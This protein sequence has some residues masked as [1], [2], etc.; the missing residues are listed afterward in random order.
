MENLPIY[1]QEANNY[2]TKYTV[3]KWIFQEHCFRDNDEL[4]A[5]K[6]TLR[7]EKRFDEITVLNDL[8]R[9]IKDN[10][11]QNIAA[12]DCVKIIIDK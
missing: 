1:V 4:F 3:L 10:V 6:K 11:L 2:T 9:L 7:D 12:L 5:F 8:F